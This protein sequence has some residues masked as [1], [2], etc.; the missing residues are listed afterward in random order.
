[1]KFDK[2][3]VFNKRDSCLVTQRINKYFCAHGGMSG[4]IKGHIRD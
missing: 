4:K 3:G 2:L 1:M